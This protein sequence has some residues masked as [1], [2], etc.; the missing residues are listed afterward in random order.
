MWR[1]CMSRLSSYSLDKYHQK[2][3][4]YFILLGSINL[5]LKFDSDFFVYYKWLFLSVNYGKNLE[6]II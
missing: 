3:K 6:K 2:H 5:I 4:P 1:E